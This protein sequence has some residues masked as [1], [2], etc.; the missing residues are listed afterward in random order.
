[1]ISFFDLL[2]ENILEGIEAC[3]FE[4][5]GIYRQLNSYENRV[6]DLDLEDGQRVVAKFYRPGRWSKDTILDE[7]E[8]VDELRAEGIP[9]VCPLELANNETLLNYEGIFI[10][11]F[12][13][14]VGRNPQEFINDD[15]KKVGRRLAQIHNVGSRRKAKHRKTLGARDFAVPALERLESWIEPTL[16][17]RYFKAADVVVDFLQDNLEEEYEN[18][19]H[20]DCHKGNL[21]DTGEEF[22]FVD[23]DDFSNGPEAQDFWMLM[24]GD[25]QDEQDMII[26]GYEELREFKDEWFDLFEPLRGLRL[27]HYAGWIAH[28]W[29]DPSFPRLFPEFNTHR[30]WAEETEALE[31]IAWEL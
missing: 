7:H 18:R 25:D 30:Y 9:A 17:D 29:E 14:I 8:F 16:K 31:R 27:I 4:P 13:K 20:G 26:D 22:S 24:S 23:F 5:T 21:I 28:R 12:P 15:L 1:M 2:P 6:F 11:V 10:A 19:I 3:G